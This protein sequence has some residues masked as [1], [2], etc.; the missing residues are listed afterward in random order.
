MI[1]R[2]ATP[3]DA[4]ALWAVLEPIVR[5]GET[6]ALPRDMTRQAALAYWLA[7]A[8][9]AFVAERD[10]EV[11]GGYYL[12]ANQMGGGAHVGNA[13]Y[14]TAPAARG[15]GIARRM[16]EHSLEAAKTLGFR[17]LQFNFV[18]SSNT[19]AVALWRSLGFAEVGRL[20][21][22]FAHPTLGEVDA[23]VMF[24]VL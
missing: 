15:Q 3:Q 18:V 21:G 16:G 22:A 6:F 2:P 9:T 13:G 23:L 11:V 8:H 5:E 20:P 10:G 12:R 17:A 7:P 4:D 24:R 1:I 14:M 19:R